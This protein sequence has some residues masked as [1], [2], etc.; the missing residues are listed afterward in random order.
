[1]NKRNYIIYGTYLAVMVII[2]IAVKFLGLPTKIGMW[3]ALAVAVGLAVFW[4]R[5]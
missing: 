3:A 2:A 5:W 1:M 4:P